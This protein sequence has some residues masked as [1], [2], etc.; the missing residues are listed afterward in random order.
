MRIGDEQIGSPASSTLLARSID[1]VNAGLAWLSEHLVAT[2][3]VRQTRMP[4][5]AASRVHE[6]AAFCVAG[7]ALIM[8]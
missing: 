3:S 8:G 4:E 7:G 1:A 5:A 2:G 6:L